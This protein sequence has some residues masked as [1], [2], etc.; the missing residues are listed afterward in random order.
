MKIFL[1]AAFFFL[2]TLNSFSQQYSQYNTGTLYDSFENPSQKIFVPD[3]SRMF[4]SN[5]LVPSFNLNVLLAG[6]AQTALK[7][8][9]FSSYYNTADLKVGAGRY[10]HLN[11]NANFYSVMFKMFPNMNGN[12]ELGFAINTKA[13]AR[14]LVS[15]ESVALFNGTGNFPNNSYDNIFNDNFNY[16]LYQ[17]VGFSYREQVT[18]QFAIGIKL[19][20]LSGVNYGRIQIDQSHIDFDKKND[21]ATLQLSGTAYQSGDGGRPFIQN[22]LPTFHNPGMSV[23]VGTSLKTPDGFTL[24]GNIKDLG[25]IHWNNSSTVDNFNNFG[26]PVTIHGLSTS[27]RED[28]I[29]NKANFIAS[30]NQLNT[31]FNTHTNG[32]LEISATKSY[33]LGNNETVRFSPTLILSKE[34]FDTRFTSVLVAPFHYQK[35]SITLTTAYND[36]NLVNFGAQF[37]IKADNSE[38]FIGSESL[39]QT[40]GFISSAIHSSV[41]T[42]QP[43]TITNPTGYTGINY[44][45]GYALKFGSVIEPN[46]N[47][48]HIPNGEKGFIGRIW[49]RIFPQDAIK[50]N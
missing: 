31:G 8:R 24:Q 36:L 42:T 48:S 29:Y 7:S 13:E 4:A 49:D 6:D 38:F 27:F 3:T 50:A 33:W 40:T 44:Y 28:S 43:Q 17:Q 16:Q 32:L 41:N 26:S 18:K 5:M 47:S 12:V 19:N 30:S 22:F 46:M 2:L 9:L 37:M 15:D 10:N 39:F 23:S 45:V 25:F 21:A 34:L 14:G 35:F 11:A 20:A 1:L